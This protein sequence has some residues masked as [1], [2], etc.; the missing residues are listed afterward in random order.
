MTMAL[1]NS[2][3]SCQGV[4]DFQHMSQKL[5]LSG[6]HRHKSRAC[7][8]EFCTHDKFDIKIVQNLFTFSL[9]G[10]AHICVNLSIIKIVH[11]RACGWGCLCLQE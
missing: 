3:P 9:W 11:A 4:L 1:E 6:V 7:T 5:L 8:L 2:S 10:H